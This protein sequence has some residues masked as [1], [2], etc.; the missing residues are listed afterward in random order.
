MDNMH[1]Q[2]VITIFWIV[3]GSKK[4]KA[5]LKEIPPILLWEL[6]KRRNSRLPDKVYSYERLCFTSLNTIYQFIKL[7]YP[8]LEIPKE[9]GGGYSSK[10]LKI[11]T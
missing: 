8:W 7:N 2:Q 6:W 9:W 3:Q 1:L 4:L 11:Q 10:A 5:G